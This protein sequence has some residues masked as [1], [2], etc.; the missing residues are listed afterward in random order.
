MP[1]GSSLN[2]NSSTLEYIEAEVTAGRQ[3]EYCTKVLP[4]HS[5]L[6]NVQ[7]VRGLVTVGL[8]EGGT[9]QGQSSL[10]IMKPVKKY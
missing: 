7:I 6:L 2:L 3:L 4:D 5:G 1:T 9:K 10:P 8:G